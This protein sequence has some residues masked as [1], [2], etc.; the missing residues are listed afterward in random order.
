VPRPAALAAL[1][2]LLVLGSPAFAGI[3]PVPDKD[4]QACIN[5][6]NADWLAVLKAQGKDTAGCLKDVA[7]GKASLDACLGA[8]TKGKV[9][10]AE[11]KT[12]QSDTKKCDLAAP[13]AFARTSPSAV[14]ASAKQASLASFDTVFGADPNVVAKASDKD[15]A[16]CQAEVLKRQAKLQETW[17]AEANKAKKAALKGSGGAPA[18]ADAEQLGAAIDLALGDS[19]KLAKARD[20]A[21]SGIG[22]KCEDA[23]V[24][25]RFD[26][27]GAATVA[28]LTAC[29]IDSAEDDACTGFELADAVPLS[30]ANDALLVGAASR[31]VL[32]LVGGS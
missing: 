10:K 6:L 27:G 18:P 13:P 15:G 29:V 19:S 31:S 3:T 25:D 30:C 9:A 21:T 22:K 17:A 8:D 12:A 11:E 20:K 1:S 2:A 14:N 23:L 7:A 26:C 24:A 5:A 32:P 28:D 4:A 16:A